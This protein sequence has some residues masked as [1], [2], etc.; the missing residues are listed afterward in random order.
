MKCPKCG[1]ANLAIVQSGPH[2][3][4]IC[5]DCLAFVK[6]LSKAEAKTWELLKEA[7]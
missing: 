3:K 7:S 2:N 4:L 6:F 1:S 5:C